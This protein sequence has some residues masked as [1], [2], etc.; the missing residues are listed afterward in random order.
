MKVS[1]A[2]FG[3]DF[4]SLTG[5]KDFDLYPHQREA[6]EK[7]AE[8]KNVLVTVPT[9]AGKTVIAY[10]GIL[11]NFRKGRK[12][13]YI[14]P[15]KALA[16]EKF[17]ELR[18]MRSLG[19]RV[20]IAI[21][22]YDVDPSTLG[23]YDVIICTSEKADSL[24]HHDP[25]FL[26]EVGLIVADELHLIGEKSRGSRLEAVLTAA[27]IVNPGTQIVA[28]SATITNAGE[29]ARWL[30]ADL[31]QSDFRPVPLTSMILYRGRY[32]D[33]DGNPLDEKSPASM[34][35]LVRTQ[36]EAGGQVIIFRNSRKRV[37]ET[38][39]Q[40]PNILPV[41]EEGRSEDTGETDRLTGII[42]EIAPRGIAFHHAG[43]PIGTRTR[44]EDH[45]RKGRIKVIVATPTLAAGVNLPARAVI[46]RDIT[47]YSG[48]VSDYISTGEVKQMMGRAGRPGYDTHGVAVI[49]ASSDM[50]FERSMRYLSEE[51][52]PVL[53]QLNS[54]ELIRF[55]VLALVASG[56]A[57]DHKGIME[58]FEKTLMHS[59]GL[60]RNVE[61]FVGESTKFL[62]ENSFLR[63]GT[64]GY[65][66]TSFG[67]MVSN[68]YIDPV[69]ALEIKRYL[70]GEFRESTAIYRV[71]LVSDI[72]YISMT[73]DDYYMVENFLD[74]NGIEDY[75]EES[76]KAAK[77]A[78]IFLDWIEEIPIRN[79]EDKYNIGYGDIQSRSSTLEWLLYS[80]A[81][82]AQMFRPEAQRRCDMLALRVREGIRE[83]IV[84]LTTIP[85]IGRVRA[86]RLYVAGLRTP[87]EVARST[88][89]RISSI[90]GFSQK[91][92]TSII[93][94]ARRITGEK[95]N[96]GTPEDP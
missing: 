91:L 84:S 54:E 60:S 77:I 72:G 68:L 88:V 26:A 10:A 51:A 27:R 4:L 6:I 96:E 81:R 52:E 3:Q 83:E 13:L 80:M 78:M 11:H 64:D 24:I 44:I 69:V 14:V 85:G 75:S 35:E 70:E 59:Q 61:K 38:A 22:D 50:G 87:K 7:V 28:L 31:V 42:D 92:A 57:S 30:D 63:K 12:S 93:A 79:I 89:E 1:E 5:G 49:F 45:F 36:V 19:A 9:A 46:I 65:R 76:Y 58:F 62:L 21:G 55:N 20:T 17:S 33:G 56:L 43:L 95:E 94:Y 48:G 25:D 23:R 90:F 15:L 16:S 71:A 53:S 73:R 18:A 82:L 34:E 40:F 39:V 86:R 47:R 2:G 41:H 74:K 29:I 8:G 67:E 37:E 32:Y 66:A